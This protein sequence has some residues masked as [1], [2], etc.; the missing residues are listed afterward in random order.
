M[1]NIM[2]KLVKSLKG[3]SFLV[4]GINENVK[5]EV[6]KKTEKGFLSMLTAALCVRLLWNMF[7]GGWITTTGEGMNRSGKDF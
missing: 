4:K 3:A 7:A 5:N 6:K 2:P 1:S